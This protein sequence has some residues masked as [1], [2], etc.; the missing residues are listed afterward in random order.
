[1]W[2]RKHRKA[3]GTPTGKPNDGK[4]WYNGE[5]VD[6]V[7]A[8]AAIDAKH[9]GWR[10]YNDDEV[11]AYVE[12]ADWPEK[13]TGVNNYA[14]K[15]SLPARCLQPEL[16]AA[17]LN[18][19]GPNGAATGECFQLDKR[20]PNQTQPV[21]PT[22]FMPGFPKSASTWLFECMHAAF[23]PETVCEPEPTRNLLSFSRRFSGSYRAPQRTFDPKRW[24]KK[25]C[26]GRRFMLPG[27]ACAVTGGCSHRKELFFYGAG[28]PPR[29]RA[30][31][32]HT[33][34]A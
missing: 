27:I 28:A 32:P 33:Q 29:R 19:K 9:K 22:L 13:P 8:A 26:K 34:P 14:G 3:A 18:A 31:A 21:L 20:S 2:R 25:G 30:A 17:D 7:A 6:P 10:T 11:P 15:Q 1:M 4:V 5:W 12:R 16:D 23:I 24:D